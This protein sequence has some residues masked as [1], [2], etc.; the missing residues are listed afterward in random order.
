MNKVILDKQIVGESR[1]VRNSKVIVERESSVK[2]E[3]YHF[4]R[5]VFDVSIGEWTRQHH[6]FVNRDQVED[7]LATLA[8]SLM[9][10]DGGSDAA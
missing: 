10:E 7:L 8:Q 1:A 2:G 6:F 3:R 9:G 5:W 4:G